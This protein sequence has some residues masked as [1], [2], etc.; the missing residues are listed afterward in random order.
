MHSDICQNTTRMFITYQVVKYDATELERELQGELFDEW[1]E[2]WETAQ[3]SEIPKEK[4]N[5]YLDSV[6]E[7]YKGKA[8][9]NK[10]C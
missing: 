1:H 9:R 7:A 8:L 10:T 4:L 3:A 6:A 5:E 2:S